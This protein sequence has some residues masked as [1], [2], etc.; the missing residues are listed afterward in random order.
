MQLLIEPLDSAHRWIIT[1]GEG[2]AADKREYLLTPVP[3]PRGLYA[4]DEQN[5]IVPDAIYIGGQ[6]YSRF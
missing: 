2:E 5:S 4:I 1:Y 3:P 6:L